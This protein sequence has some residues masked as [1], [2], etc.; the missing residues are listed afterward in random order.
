MAMTQRALVPDIGG[1]AANAWVNGII[2]CMVDVGVEVFHCAVC[3]CGTWSRFPAWDQKTKQPMSGK[4]GISENAWLLDDFD[5]DAQPIKLVD[6][7]N[8]W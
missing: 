3:G 8:P 1:P 4:F 2:A 6:G 7:K 5:P